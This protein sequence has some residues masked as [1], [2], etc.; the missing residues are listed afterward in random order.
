MVPARDLERRLV[1]LR[2]GRQP[3]RAS[4]LRTHGDGRHRGGVVRRQGPRPRCGARRPRRG[5]RARERCDAVS[6]SSSSAPT[7]L[8]RGAL[9]ARGYREVRRFYEMAIQLDASRRRRTSR[10]GS[11][12]R[13]ARRRA[14]RSTTRSTKRSRITGSSRRGRSRSGGPG[15]SSATNFDPTLWFLI[16][17][18]DEIA[19]VARNER[20]ETAVATS[21]RSASGAAWR[22]SGLGEALL[23]HDVRASSTRRGTTRVTL[24]V[25]AENPTGATQ[26]YERVGMH[27][28][29]ERTSS[30]RR[31]S[32]EHASRAK[33][34]DCRTLT[35]VAVGPDY[36][37]HSL[38]PH[39]AAGLVRVPRA[40]GDGGEP[41]IEAASLPLDYPEASIVEEDTL[42]AQT[43]AVASDLPARP[44]VLGGCCCSHIGAVEG[45]AARH[46]RLGV[47]WFDAHGDLNTPETSPSGNEWGMPLRMIIDG[48]AV[49]RGRR[50]ARRRA[51]PR[52]ARGRV[53]RAAGIHDDP[54]AVLDRV[55]GVYV[56]L[57]CDVFDPAS[58]RSCM[59]E[60]G[61]PT[62]RRGRAAPRADRGPRGARRRRR[63]H[64]PR[65]R[66][67]RTSRS[68]SGCR[69]P[70]GSERR[71]QPPAAGTGLS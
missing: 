5:A 68:S 70:S 2:G 11:P 50:R 64:R 45:L 21:A 18:G 59:P 10:P 44:L 61:G 33:C 8:P 48:G 4:R 19:A 3:A 51:Q 57:D 62:R 42:R 23:L 25:D 69:R 54:D 22:G 56:A 12:G 14:R 41:M 52:P 47:I 6:I 46:D 37:C 58:S 43:L 71:P 28:E 32:H 66:P 36:E 30:S 39:F 20:T 63:A 7:P 27:V 55:D 65:A 49:A 38:R 29:R 67:G 1:A 53:H 17:D 24:G 34:P 16:R 15:G 9:R 35:A 26:L 31:R 60:P 40:W 13:A